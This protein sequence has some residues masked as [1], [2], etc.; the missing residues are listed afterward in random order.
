MS[1]YRKSAERGQWPSWID[2]KIPS[3][4]NSAGLKHTSDH[5]FS[6]PSDIWPLGTHD[7]LGSHH[8]HQVKGLAALSL[9]WLFMKSRTNRTFFNDWNTTIPKQKMTD[10]KQDLPFFI[11]SNS[12][13]SK[14]RQG[15]LTLSSISRNLLPLVDFL[16]CEE[17]PSLHL[18]AKQLKLC[19]QEWSWCC[20]AV[21]WNE[22]WK[23][24]CRYSSCTCEYLFL[25]PL[26]PR[27]LSQC[28]TKV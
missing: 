10:L 4:E 12:L 3:F 8:T 27:P 28:Y 6:I 26:Y 22:E 24:E 23:C 15:S 5:G 21:R 7:H 16:L 1:W 25:S 2:H 18:A 19:F 13:G 17:E 20:F 9:L 14:A 11:K